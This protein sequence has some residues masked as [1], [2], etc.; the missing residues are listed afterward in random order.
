M[1]PISDQIRRSRITLNKESDLKGEKIGFLVISRVPDIFHSVWH[2]SE[3]ETS[4]FSNNGKR[5]TQKW[6]KMIEKL[7]G[8]SNSSW[9]SL[10]RMTLVMAKMSNFNPSIAE[11]GKDKSV[12][13]VSDTF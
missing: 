2:L 6:E 5:M 13:G 7:F 4:D 10:L 11:A 12:V 3:S 9:Y 1:K 8:N